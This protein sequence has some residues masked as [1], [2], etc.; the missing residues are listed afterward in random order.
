MYIMACLQWASR[1]YLCWSNMQMSAGNLIHRFSK[2][3]KETYKI[4]EALLGL[5]SRMYALI[6][7]MLFMPLFFF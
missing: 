1:I 3:L 6:Y 7:N 2:D 4:I 5:C